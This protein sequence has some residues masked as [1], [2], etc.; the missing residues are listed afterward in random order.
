M[1][2]PPRPTPQPAPSTLRPTPTPRRT[3]AGRRACRRAHS[4]RGPCPASRRSPPPPTP[5]SSPSPR[6]RPPDVGQ[7]PATPAAAPTRTVRS[8]EPAPAPTPPA[9]APPTNRPPPRCRRRQTQLH[10]APHRPAAD[11]TYACSHAIHSTSG[12]SHRRRGRERTVGNPSPTVMDSELDSRPNAG[13]GIVRGSD[14][15]DVRCAR[16]WLTPRPG[17]NRSE[18]RLWV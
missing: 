15:G 3:P 16:P 12:V 1:A 7:P 13:Y 6:V 11:R 4:H 10:R 9:A 17:V 8:S 2:A 18:C 5:P 14:A